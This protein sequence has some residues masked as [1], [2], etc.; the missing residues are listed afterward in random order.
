MGTQQSI[1]IR[2]GNIYYADLMAVVGSGPGGIW[3]VLMVQN[4]MG[5]QP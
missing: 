3:P 2:C 5:N 4:N 1:P